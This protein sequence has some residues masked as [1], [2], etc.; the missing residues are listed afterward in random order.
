MSLE[1]ANKSTSKV[2]E[3]LT[4]GFITPIVSMDGDLTGVTGELLSNS[5][6]L[7]SE[8][9]NLDVACLLHGIIP[10]LNPLLFLYCM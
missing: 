10:R 9:L 8:F 4:S 5:V 7:S 3:A 2:S 6:K 1:N